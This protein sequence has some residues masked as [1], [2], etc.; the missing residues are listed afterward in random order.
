MCYCMYTTGGL[1]VGWSVENW[2]GQIELPL[3][4]NYCT[5]GMRSYL[6]VIQRFEGGQNWY[7]WYELKRV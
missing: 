7:D 1:R 5:I 6:L 4:L 2:Q 3:M